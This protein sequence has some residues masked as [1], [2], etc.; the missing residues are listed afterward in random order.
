M[1][2]KEKIEP[3][4]VK[5]EAKET[6]KTYKVSETKTKAYIYK[7]QAYTEA[8]AI[9]EVQSGNVL[10]ECSFTTDVFYQIENWKKEQKKGI[11]MINQNEIVGQFLAGLVHNTMAWE[12]ALDGDVVEDIAK[13]FVKE[14]NELNGNT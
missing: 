11:T 8:A 4:G 2:L 10:K 7:V 3:Y 9:K 14:L 5:A 12:E 6:I 1:K 13:A